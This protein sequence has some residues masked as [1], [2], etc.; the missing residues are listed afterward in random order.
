M[1]EKLAG[2]FAVA[3]IAETFDLRSE[4][5]RIGTEYTKAYASVPE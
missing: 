2:A 5:D 3:G 1:F 4:I